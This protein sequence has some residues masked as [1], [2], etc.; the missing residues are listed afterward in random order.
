MMQRKKSSQRLASAGCGSLGLELHHFIELRRGEET[1]HRVSARVGKARSPAG[2]REGDGIALRLSYKGGESEGP[3][4]DAEVAGISPA[5]RLSAEPH[6]RV[7]GNV[8][9]ELA[10]NKEPLADPLAM[11]DLSL[12]RHDRGR[13][14]D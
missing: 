12:D 11:A 8:V 7:P 6:A 3:R 2:P 14:F 5:G 9:V 13:G 4:T 1:S 10:A